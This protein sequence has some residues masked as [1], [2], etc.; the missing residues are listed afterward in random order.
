MAITRMAPNTVWLSGDKVL[1]NDIGCSEAITP[2]M[3][4]ER[5]TSTGSKFRKH[6]TAGGAGTIVALEQDML[7]KGVDDA[8]A[9]GDLVEAAI[10]VPGS[11]FWMFVGSGANIAAG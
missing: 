1:V 2:G 3:L 7:N 10:G 6:A 4:I 11:T 8:Y 5:I 9:A